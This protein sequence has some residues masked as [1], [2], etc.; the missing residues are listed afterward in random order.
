MISNTNRKSRLG[1]QH[2][3]GNRSVRQIMVSMFHCIHCCFCYS[4]LELIQTLAWQM[5]SLNGFSDLL[6][7]DAFVAW[8]AGHC[9]FSKSFP[10]AAVA[11]VPFFCRTDRS[12][13][14]F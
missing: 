13:S 10:I 9:Q 5:E 6:H 7:C 4:S 8:L 11:R 12:I 3:D 1:G 14:D 2:F